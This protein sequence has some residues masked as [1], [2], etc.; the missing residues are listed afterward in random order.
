M[1]TL[2]EN[3]RDSEQDLRWIAWEKENKRTDRITEKR[4]AVAFISAGVILL[5]SILYVLLQIR[6]GAL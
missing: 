3:A 6:S 4:M 5:M 1:M 2:A